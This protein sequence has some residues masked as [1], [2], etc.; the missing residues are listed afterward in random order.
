MALLLPCHAANLVPRP[1]PR[2]VSLV[3]VPQCIAGARHGCADTEDC[4]GALKCEK[5]N[6]TM[7]TGT[8]RLV[9]GGDAQRQTGSCLG[10][11]CCC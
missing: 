4:C 9:S 3:A 1:Y 5:L 8:C 2:S 11:L 6:A 7:P 10:C